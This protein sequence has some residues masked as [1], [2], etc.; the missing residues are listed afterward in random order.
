MLWE[1]TMANFRYTAKGAGGKAVNGTTSAATEAE[2]VA[3]LQGQ[4]LVVLK[5]QPEGAGSVFSMSF[6]GGDPR[7]HVGADDM[8]LFTRQLATMI[9]AGIP[10]SGL[11]AG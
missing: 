5:I 8:V 3:Q 11:P 4:N 10:L 6:F 1:E 7:P 9:G 2:A